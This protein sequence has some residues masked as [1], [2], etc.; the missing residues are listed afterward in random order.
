MQQ[1]KNN[2]WWTALKRRKNV[3]KFKRIVPGNKQLLPNATIVLSIEEVNAVKVE[4]GFDLMDPKMMK[5]IMNEYFLLAF[6]VVDSSQ[7][8]AYFMFDGQDEPQAMSF[9]GME[10][11]N[12]SKNDFKEIYKLINSGRL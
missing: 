1:Q 12:N 8:I 6:V 7:E 4:H 10:R 11:E 5:R 2:A 9:T 3:A